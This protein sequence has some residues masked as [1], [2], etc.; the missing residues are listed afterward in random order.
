MKGEDARLK[1]FAVDDMLGRLAKW[2]RVLGFDVLYERL[3]NGEQINRLVQQDYIVITRTRKWCSLPQVLCPDS[4]NPVEQFREVVAA[5]RIFPDEIHPL[6]R[7]IR[8]NQLLES[9]SRSEVFG[10]IPDF[11]FET[12]TAFHRCIDCG[13][14][15]WPGSH[16]KRMMA[17]I[18]S[19][20]G[21]P[22]ETKQEKED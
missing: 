17:H 3:L 22:L 9:V 4:N 14:I 21:W 1:R 12:Q 18:R 5:A 20:L 13:R 11:V 6:H 7:C 15:Y 10:L 2:L 8:C 16:S 19:E